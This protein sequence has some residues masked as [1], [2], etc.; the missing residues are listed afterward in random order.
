MTRLID[1]G[2]E[3]YLVSASLTIV[4]AQRL[5]RT[6]CVTCAGKGRIAEHPCDA[7]HGSGFRGRS[8]IFELLTMDDELR[9]AI[10]A[11]AG[12]TFLRQT[13][14]DHGMCTLAEA[15]AELVQ[16]GRTTAAEVE[17]VIHHG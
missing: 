15:G 2:V 3:P 12:L 6:C 17:R 7:C 14:R 4:L 10:I 9:S 13:A 1:L 5:V 8:G 16:A 11:D